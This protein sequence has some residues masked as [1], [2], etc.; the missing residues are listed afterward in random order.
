MAG[1]DKGNEVE[2]PLRKAKTGI[3]EPVIG[4][5]DRQGWIQRKNWKIASVTLVSD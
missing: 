4:N 5:S 2:N 1:D 3:Y